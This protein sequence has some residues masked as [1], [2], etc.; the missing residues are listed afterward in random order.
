[1]GQGMLHRLISVFIDI[2]GNF[3][4]GCDCKAIEDLAILVHGIMSRRSRQF[5]T[6]EHVFGFIE[7]ADYLTALGAVFHDLIYYQVD[8]GLPAELSDLLEGYVTLEADGIHVR[9]DIPVN[10]KAFQV[11]CGLFCI[12]PGSVLKPNGG[13]NEFLSALAMLKL[14]SSYLDYEQL[15][16][17]LVCIEASI[18]FRGTN[19]DG[20]S[21]G[22]TLEQRLKDLRDE[23]LVASND[24]GIQ[25]MV[26][27]A[28]IFANADVRDFSLSDPGHFLSNTWKLLPESNAALRHSNLYTIRDYRK[29]LVGMCGFL[30]SLSPDIIYHTYRGVPDS[31]T[32]ALLYASA[33]KNLHCA[34]DYFE[35]KILATGILDAIASLSGGDVPVALFMGELPTEGLDDEC[36]TDFLPVLPMPDWLDKDDDVYRLLKDGRLDESS[37]DLRNSP[38]A[39][40]LYLRLEPDIWKTSC[41]AAIGYARDTMDAESF[42]AV[43]PKDVLGDLL[44]ASVRMVPT[45]RSILKG[46]ME[47]L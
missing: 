40:H 2:S 19:E 12:R 23:G 41:A 17:V 29:A 37:F 15:V 28:V 31:K 11:L 36:F 21:V 10:D 20:L 7:G 33:V 18:P 3:K 22:E 35:A 32:M 14:V 47:E 9:E 44:E 26:T 46:M 39:M 27:R 4:K 1:M 38:L 5:H 43:L 8:N 13:L 42:L 24:A 45:R 6:L 30:G 16:A 34:M 25:A